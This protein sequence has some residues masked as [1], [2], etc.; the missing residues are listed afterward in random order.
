M[1]GISFT[2][3]CLYT[4][5]YQVALEWKKEHDPQDRLRVI[6]TGAASGRLGT[7]VLSCTRYLAQTNNLEKTYEFAQKAVK[8]CEEYVFLDKLQYLAAGGR[9]SKT[10]A[11]FGDMLKMK[12]VISPQ[13]QG[14]IKVGVVRNREEQ[15]K[16]ALEKVGATLKKDSNALIMLEYSD[17]QDWVEGTIKPILKERYPLADILLQPLSLTSGAHMGPGTWGV[18]FL[19]E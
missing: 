5:N 8:S 6:D 4:G 7:I 1:S 2:Q 11:F 19:P 9:L 14:V 15:I 12:P 3:A 18:A 13:P 17:N 10:S 16:L